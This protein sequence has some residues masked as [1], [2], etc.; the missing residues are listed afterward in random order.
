MLDNVNRIDSTTDGLTIVPS[1]DIRVVR[2]QSLY[3]RRFKRPFDMV[4]G[5]LL[6]VISAPA[7]L[8][9][10]LAVRFGLGKSVLYSQERI[11]VGGTPFTIYKF[12]TMRPD[13][14]H[15]EIG[16]T[17]DT[18]RRNTHKDDNDPRH[19]GFG[20]LLRRLSLDELPQ[21]INVL[22][23]EMSLVGPRPELVGVARERGYLCHPRHDVRPG[24]TGPYQVSDLRYNG[25]LRDGLELDVDYVNSLT[26]RNDMRYLAKT[27]TVMLSGSSGS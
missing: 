3:E 20:R 24:M 2:E 1:D 9:V 15:R 5:S 8:G 7:F 18:D 6:L 16:L 19:T 22:R 4:F 13:R 25:D 23:G 10:A 17:D 27:V 21:L 14:R 12:R 26:F 11:S